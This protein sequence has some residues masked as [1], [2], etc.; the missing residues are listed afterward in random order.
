MAFPADRFTARPTDEQLPRRLPPTL[1]AGVPMPAPR[2]APIES[3]DRPPLPAPLVLSTNGIDSVNLA[4]EV[5]RVVPASGNLTAC[6]QQFWLAPDRAGIPLTLWA[7]RQRFRR[8][9]G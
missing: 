3:Q 5:T 9:M 1:A 4:V 7:A 8:R 2:P 6:G